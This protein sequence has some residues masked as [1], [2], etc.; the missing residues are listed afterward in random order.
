MMVDGQI[1]EDV[2]VSQGEL[3]EAKRRYEEWTKGYLLDVLGYIDKPSA[4]S[5]R[6]KKI[7][8]SEI[9]RLIKVGIVE[10]NVQYLAMKKEAEKARKKSA[11]LAQIDC[12]EGC[13]FRPSPMAKK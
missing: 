12:F 13:A 11:E 8:C 5:L 1:S 7:G 9:V 2:K 10:R 4:E 6:G 3:I